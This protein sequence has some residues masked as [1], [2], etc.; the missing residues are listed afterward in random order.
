MSI[1]L[2]TRVF[3]QCDSCTRQYVYRYS[4]PD[5]DASGLRFKST[6]RVL[7]TSINSS[8]EEQRAIIRP[9]LKRAINYFVRNWATFWLIVHLY[10]T[11]Y[12][13]NVCYAM[14]CYA[15]LCYAMLCFAMLCMNLLGQDEAT[16]KTTYPKLM[17]MDGARKEARRQVTWNTYST[18][19]MWSTHH[20]PEHFYRLDRITDLD[21]DLLLDTAVDHLDP[22]CTCRYVWA[23]VQELYYRTRCSRPVS[24]WI[25]YSSCS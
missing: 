24:R 9:T 7:G 20:W 6:F 17:G 22:S 13:H 16:S 2:R 15:L 12:T 19:K 1:H 21:H 11:L 4:L 25:Y 3:L 8:I 23:V 14:L 10:L 5:V 18:R